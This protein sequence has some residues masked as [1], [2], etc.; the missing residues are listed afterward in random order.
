MPADLKTQIPDPDHTFLE[1]WLEQ[2]KSL[3]MREQQMN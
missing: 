1:Q 3:T 2:L